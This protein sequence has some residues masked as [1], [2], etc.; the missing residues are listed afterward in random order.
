MANGL[1]STT[2]VPPFDQ[3]GAMIDLS[4]VVPVYRGSATIRELYRR[5]VEVVQAHGLTFEILFV[6]DCGG[7]DSWAIIQTLA[8]EDRRVRGFRMQ[9]NYGQE[10][11]L[12]A[13]IRAA[14]GQTIATLDDDLQHPPEELPKLLDKLRD[15]FDVVYGS[16]QREQHSF[17][18]N[19]ASRITKIA[20]QTSMGVEAARYISSFRVFR[21][22]LRDAF[23]EYRSSSVSIDVLLIWA[24]D[25]FAVV[26]VDHQSR[27]HG[28][29]GYTAIKLM[30]HAVNMATGFTTLPLRLA[31]LIGFAFATFGILMLGYVLLEYFIRGN[32]V[33]G[34]PFLAS[35]ITLFS[36]AQLVALGIVGEY[37]ARMYQRSMGKPAY[38]VRETT[39]PRT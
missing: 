30:R 10:N 32:P 3:A 18:R 11:A 27:Q 29:S 6:E 34:F 22:S 4:I 28:D 14:R 16:P 21:T 36:G 33:P 24:T 37:L 35:I 17:L 20:L 1:I 26:R 39:E 15:D 25:R 2:S 23:S 38:L 7:D 8:A 31:S 19:V 5:V 12:L 13:G 9:R